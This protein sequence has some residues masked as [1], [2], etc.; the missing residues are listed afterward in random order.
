MDDCSAV[1][2]PSPWL[3]GGLATATRRHHS[4]T[5]H[6]L[7]VISEH[8][9]RRLLHRLVLQSLAHLER[10]LPLRQ[11][12]ALASAYGQGRC[13][14]SGQNVGGCLHLTPLQADRQPGFLQVSHPHFS[15]LVKMK[16]MQ[17]KVRSQGMLR[18]LTDCHVTLQTVCVCVCVCAAAPDS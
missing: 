5:T 7:I 6:L 10:R 12:L 15:F 16:S 11:F 14:P 3:E 18:H 2:P 4:P 17:R 8:S 9:D 13:L 1:W